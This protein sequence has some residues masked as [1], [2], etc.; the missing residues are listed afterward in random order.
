[1]F[2]NYCHV[3]S[4]VLYL[5][6][7]YYGCVESC[8]SDKPTDCA[9]DLEY[10][11]HAM[12]CS[13]TQERFCSGA[14]V[15]CSCVI[16]A[17]QCVVQDGAPNK[18]F[19]VCVRQRQHSGSCSQ[20]GQKDCLR[21]FK[22]LSV[23]PHHKFATFTANDIA[24]IKL[25]NANPCGCDSVV[26]V[27]LPSKPQDGS[28]SNAE[29]V[30]SAFVTSWGKVNSSNTPVG[31]LHKTEIRLAPSY[32]GCELNFSTYRIKD[33]PLNNGICA[34]DRGGPLFKRVDG[35]ECHHMLAGIVNLM[36]D[37]G[38]VRET[39]VYTRVFTHLEWVEQMCK[40]HW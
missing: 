36:K 12:L 8:P 20:V 24:V 10:F 15:G 17:A 3:C 1:M 2:V 22:P 14:L 7:L 31:C 28:Q 29:T 38:T 35:H 6:N 18:N 39:G 19:T 4:V 32:P 40:N 21:C 16:T 11:W 33:S 30:T 26:P 13:P 25:G 27:C 37:C 34:S 9:T 5:D 23:T